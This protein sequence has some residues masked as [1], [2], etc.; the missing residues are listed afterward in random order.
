MSGSINSGRDYEILNVTLN[1]STDTA[2]TF[3]NRV[4]SAV[5]HCRSAVDVYIR[6]ESEDSK[7]F[8]IPSGG[9]L[10]IDVSKST[11]TPFY[12]RSASST[13]VLEVIGTYE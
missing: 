7:Y 2:I 6:R 4:T 11:V 13:P 8:T 5:F 3:N 9:S 10:T 12:A 1:S